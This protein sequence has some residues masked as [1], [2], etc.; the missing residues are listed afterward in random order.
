MSTFHTSSVDPASLAKSLTDVDFGGSFNYSTW[1]PIEEFIKDVLLS[2][3]VKAEQL[4]DKISSAIVTTVVG[5]A[6][7]CTPFMDVKDD[8]S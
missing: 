7:K 1:D 8:P 2:R 4:H 3:N 6:D 5:A